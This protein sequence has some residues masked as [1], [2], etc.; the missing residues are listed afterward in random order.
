MCIIVKFNFFGE[1]DS[2]I[3]FDLDLWNLYFWKNSDKCRDIKFP[4]P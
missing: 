1:K 4:K 2:S 3:R